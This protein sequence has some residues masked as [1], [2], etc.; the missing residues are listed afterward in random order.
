MILVV[1]F[2]LS[3]AV[4]SVEL[5]TALFE[6]SFGADTLDTTELMVDRST[7]SVK[8]FRPGSCGV[9]VSKSA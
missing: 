5:L 3:P 6:S 4:L 7:F 2:G 9:C 1:D 8:L